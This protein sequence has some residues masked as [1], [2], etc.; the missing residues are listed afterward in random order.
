M[1]SP[2]A[3]PYTALETTEK[4]ITG[5]VLSGRQLAALDCLATRGDDESIADV[6]K[7]AG[8]AYKTLY[9]Y[10]K[11]K[12]FIAE[13]KARVDVE[14]GAHRQPIAKALMKG[15]L[16]PGMGQAALQKLYWQKLGEFSEKSEVNVSGSVGVDHT[17]YHVFNTLPAEKQALIAQMLY[18]EGEGLAQGEANTPADGDTLDAEYVVGDE[19]EPDASD[20]QPTTVVP[21]YQATDV[22]DYQDSKPQP[23]TGKRQA[24]TLD[25]LLD[26][27]EPAPGLSLAV[28]EKVS[29]AGRMEAQSVA[30]VDGETVSPDTSPQAH[31]ALRHARLRVVGMPVAWG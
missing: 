10:L 16:K 18:G 14:L 8:I 30:V 2:T 13:L 19:D 11:D 5:A 6:A 28:D 22:S 4:C 21:A 23:Q 17:H 25:Q 9:V 24:L 26:E 29:N 1:I 7:R 15:A 12:D 20:S 31:H 27:D 3:I